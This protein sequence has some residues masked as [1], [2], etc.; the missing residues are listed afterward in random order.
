MIEAAP[1]HVSVTGIDG[2]GKTTVASDL[3]TEIGQEQKVVRSFSNPPYSIEYGQ[4]FDHF[5]LLSVFES[6]RNLAG[7]QKGKNFAAGVYIA[8]TLLHSKIIEPILERRVKPD[9]TISARDA[10]VDAAVYT[11][12]YSNP[13][14]PEN[15]QQRLTLLQRTTRIPFRDIIFF[16]RTPPHIALQRIQVRDRLNRRQP[17]QIHEDPDSLTQLQTVY[18]QILSNLDMRGI[19]TVVDISTEDLTQEDVVAKIR[20][21]IEAR[22]SERKR[23]T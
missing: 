2:S 22:L 3:T 17:K 15:A 4:R 8:H 6:L 21:V 9:L 10:L 11:A 14:I 23:T 19:C 12:F 18:E 13:L 20:G 1:L 5:P 7:H 16:L